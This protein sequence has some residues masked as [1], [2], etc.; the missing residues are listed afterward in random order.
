[1][2]GWPGIG[3]PVGPDQIQ[4]AQAFVHEPHNDLH[5]GNER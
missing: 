1:M 2:P 4:G 5:N 3:V